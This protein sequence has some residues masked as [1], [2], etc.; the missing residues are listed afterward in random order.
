[1]KNLI[2]TVLASALVAGMAGEAAASLAL[3]IT[4]TETFLGSPNDQDKTI[5][6][7]NNSYYFY[8]DLTSAGSG[9]SYYLL[10]DTGNKTGITDIAD[11]AYGFPAGMN[12]NILSAQLSYTFYDTD[13]NG[14]TAQVATGRSDGG[15][16]TTYQLDLHNGSGHNTSATEI[17]PLD[18]GGYLK[19]GKLEVIFSALNNTDFKLEQVSLTVAPQTRT[20]YVPLP[21]AGL[22]LASGL[23]GLVV[24]RRKQAV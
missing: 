2:I 15:L 12:T 7:K 5:V 14:E 24:I 6:Q 11:D 13:N 9:S 3:P 18:I 20:S 1:M 23:L 8:F 22:L 19:D 16:S 10:N 4:Y 21:A 17:F